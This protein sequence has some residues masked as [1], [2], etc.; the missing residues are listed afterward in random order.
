MSKKIVVNEEKRD[1]LAEGGKF[2]QT[3][4][5]SGAGGNGADRKPVILLVDDDPLMLQFYGGGLE[6][7]GFVVKE[8]QSSVDSITAFIH[9]KPDLVILDLVMPDLNGFAT[10]RTIRSLPG[11]EYTPILIITGHGDSRSVKQA[12][13]S[14]ATDY[15][16]K[17]VNL[18]LFCHR[19]RYML[20]A[21]RDI[22]DKKRSEDS[23][24]LLKEA[25]ERLPIG[26]TIS[27]LEGKIIY[28]NPAE[29]EMHGYTLE[30]LMR[31]EARMFGPP[32]LRKPLAADKFHKMTVWKRETLNLRKGGE[33]FPVQ[34]TSIPVKNSEGVPLGIITT[35]EDI[36]DRKEA[37]VAIERLA[38]HDSL[39]GLPNRSMFQDRLQK[40]LASARRE[41]RQLGVLFLDLDRFKDI[42][43]TQGHEFGD[44]LL[45]AVALRLGRCVRDADTLARLGGDEFVILLTGASDRAGTITAAE[46]ILA[47]FTEPFELEGRQVYSSTSIGVAL[48]PKDGRDVNDL[49][50]SADTAMYHAKAGGRQ[51]YRFFSE[52]INRKITEK[53]HIENGLRR[54]LERQE[55]CLYYQ[56]QIE[57]GSER[58]IGVEVLLRWMSPEMGVVMPSRFIPVAEDSGLIFRLGEWVLRTA[59][60]QSAA[61]RDAGHP[62]LRMA[63]NIS[64]HQFK[65]PSFVSLIDTVLDESSMDPTCLEFELTESVIMD[66]AEKTTL[67]LRELKDRGIHLS[68]DDF[69]TGYSSLSYLKHFPIDRIKIDRSFIA[70]ITS[71]RDEAVIVDTIIAIARSMDLKVVAEGVENREQLDYLKARRCGEAQGYYFAEPM[72]AESL[73]TWIR[74]D[75]V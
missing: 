54:A 69:G 29:A 26:I 33:K 67:T 51:T 25:V 45:R 17:P 3:S 71:N 70:D 6:K 43:D 35:C 28:A 46:R 36:T 15:I 59:C 44:K 56:P 34:L 42:N 23:L 10:C 4:D 64:G 53:V 58:I 38:Y 50:R 49:L 75:V 66:K 24:R 48:Y 62:P 74:R 1:G 60:R 2:R 18:D 63:I 57:L 72:P 47:L 31:R 37:E 21:S 7:A 73:E 52:E 55:F 9:L 14:G 8:A 16:I 68:I 13:E 5:R 22:S 27:D 61:W 39:T 11:S 32:E 12:F 65:Q 41:G 19:I 30:E 20:G 40:A